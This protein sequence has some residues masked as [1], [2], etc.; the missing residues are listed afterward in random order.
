M[1]TILKCYLYFH[2]DTDFVDEF[3]YDNGTG[4]IFGSDFE[5]ERN[6]EKKEKEEKEKKKEKW[7]KR[8]T[9]G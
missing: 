7:E 3:D 9:G 4:G 2:R 5:L 1:F 8:D 6:E